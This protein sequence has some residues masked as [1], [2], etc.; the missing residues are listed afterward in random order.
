MRVKCAEKTQKGKKVCNR[1][2]QSRRGP[3]NLLAFKN[4]GLPKKKSKYTHDLVFSILI[5][6]PFDVG[7]LR[8][9]DFS[10]ASKYLNM[11]IAAPSV[12]Y[13]LIIIIKRKKKR[14][15]GLLCMKWTEVHHTIATEFML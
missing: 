11:Y 7:P 12:I 4:I 6:W 3:L 5:V 10:N 8:S 1:H 15:K 13:S 14:K 9:H 2:G